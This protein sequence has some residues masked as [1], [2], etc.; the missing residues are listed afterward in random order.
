MAGEDRKIILGGSTSLNGSAAGDQVS[1]FW[2]PSTGLDDP[3]KLNPIASPL[4]S[5]TYTLNVVSGLGC[6]TAVDQ[7]FVLVYNELSIPASFSPN[8]D[9]T[10]DVWNITAIDTYLKPK[11]SIMNRYGELIYE[12][13]DYYLH[14]WNGK[15]KNVDVPVGVYYYLIVL[16]PDIKPRSGSL[17][18]LR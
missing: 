14:P 3:T 10:N 2:T 13:S 17:T 18:L 4:E 8:G 9:G 7:A 6:I 16:A 12:S 15:H 5:T 1:Y 11:V